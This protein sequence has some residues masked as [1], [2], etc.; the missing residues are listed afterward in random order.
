MPKVIVPIGFDGGTWYDTAPD[1]DSEIAEY[2]VVT[3]TD[4]VTLSK[5]EYTI[6]Q[7]TYADPEASSRCEFG[8]STLE[9]LA[10]LETVATQA[11]DKPPVDVPA[12]VDNLSKWGTL[13]EFD[14]E[15]ESGLEFLRSHRLFPTGDALGNSLDDRLYFRIG[16]EGRVLLKVYSDIYTI[17]SRSVYDSSIWDGVS[18]FHAGLDDPQMTAEQIGV[19]VAR[20]LPAIVANRCAY[21]QQS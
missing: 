17:W 10:T 18:Q 1:A 4:T 20:S 3:A 15:T 6:W 7:L 2:E 12:V 21:L 5:D 9:E 16:R 13:A 19:L 14:P 8:R 11:P